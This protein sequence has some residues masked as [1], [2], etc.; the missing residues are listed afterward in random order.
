MNIAFNHMNIMDVWFAEM[1][2]LLFECYHVPSIVYGV[3]SLFSLYNNHKSPSQCFE[4]LTLLFN[5][6]Y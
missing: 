3:D 5:L 4:I 1:S 2:E 6:S